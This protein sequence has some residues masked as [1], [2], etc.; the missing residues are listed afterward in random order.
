MRLYL[1][2]TDYELNAIDINRD[3]VLRAKNTNVLDCWFI[4]ENGV[5]IDITDS[6]IYF[7]IKNKSS[8]ADN[9]AIL[10]KKIIVFTDPVNG[11]AEI[12]L[13]SLDTAD[14]LGNYIYQIKIKY[15]SKWYTVAEGTICFQKNIIIR[16]T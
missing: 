14:L 10:D 15:D 7:M 8:D 2:I 16:E 6:E 12:E 11:N 13:T 5:V 1:K 4:D 3:L 9:I